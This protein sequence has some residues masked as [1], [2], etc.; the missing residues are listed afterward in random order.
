MAFRNR[1]VSMTDTARK[2]PEAEDPAAGHKLSFTFR[3]AQAGDLPALYAI[4][5][6]C[7][8]QYGLCPEGHEE[9]DD[10][11]AGRRAELVVAEDR[12][13]HVL[14]F[15][16]A[17]ARGLLFRKEAHVS[18]LGVTGEARHHGLGRAF[19]TRAQDEAA[20]RGARSITLAVSANNASAVALYRGL[21]YRE[22]NRVEKFYPDG[23]AGIGLE[24]ILG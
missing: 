22:Y 19:M 9:I 18:M 8:G 13:G 4:H 1:S 21:G 17:Y 24:K 20:A 23:S 12:P 15:S 16:L 7:F 6:E 3:K 11:L 5:D 14:G 2:Y 10:A